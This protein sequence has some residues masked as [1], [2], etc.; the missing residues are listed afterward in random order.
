MKIK[1]KEQGA[2]APRPTFCC[3]DL[4]KPILAFHLQQ[5]YLIVPLQTPY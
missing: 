1:K 4:T 3:E 2:E 5:K